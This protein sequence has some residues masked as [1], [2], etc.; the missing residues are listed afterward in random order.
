MPQR[1]DVTGAVQFGCRLHEEGLDQLAQHC[2][3]GGLGELMQQQPVKLPAE[4]SER[5]VVAAGESQ[6]RLDSSKASVRLD[7][8]AA[9]VADLAAKGV[10]VRPRGR[11]KK[12]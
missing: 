12:S 1:G 4:G 3:Y 6:L 5:R 10:A 7:A 11:Q 2:A 9:E 8:T